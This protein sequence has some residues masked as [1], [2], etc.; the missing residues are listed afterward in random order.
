MTCSINTAMPCPTDAPVDCIL[1]GDCTQVL[2]TLPS[3]YA[4][5]CVSDPPYLV[6]Y[7]DR[8]GRT[9]ANDKHPDVIVA[10]FAEV[11]RV[12]KPNTLCISFYGWNHVDAFFHAWRGAGFKPVGHLVWRKTYSSRVGFLKARHEQAY[13][14]AK[15]FPALPTT[16]LEDVQAWDYTGNV[17]HPTEK[18]TQ[19]LS[20]LI[21]SFS[22]PGH[23]VL[24]PFCGAGSTALAAAMTGRRYLG[25]ELDASYCTI[26][27]ERIARWQ[28][29]HQSRCA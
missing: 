1:N 14:L 19:V 4:D 24:D 23:L 6:G 17:F 5:I 16:P 7:R 13:L 2:T 9:I 20:P 15:G 26:A 10:A 29:H 25:I 22:Q 21:E 18:S 11:Y 3:A 8:T 27:R 28:A 12:L